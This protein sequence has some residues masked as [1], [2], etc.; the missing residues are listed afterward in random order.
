[1]DGKDFARHGAFYI[2]T[3]AYAY[4]HTGEEV[5]LKAIETIVDRFERKGV[6]AEGVRVATLGTLDLHMAAE[7]VPD[8]LSNKLRTFAAREDELILNSVVTMRAE[9]EAAGQEVFE[10]TWEARYS[11]GVTATQ[12][13]YYVARYEQI[14]RP[15]YRELVIEI[16]DVYH[17]TQPYEDAD[18]WPMSFGHIISTQVAAYHYTQKPEYLDQAERFAKMAI[19]RFWEDR[20]IP[21][22][23]LKTG[24]YESITGPDTLALALLQLHAALHKL[25]IP[26]P[27]NTLD[28]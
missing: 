18:C 2:G 25:D 16:A 24:H 10:P 14:K 22:A 6:N 26:I 13:M 5:F 4:K 20:P 17:G 21:R 15:E 12:A 1:V 8:P 23:S 7:R 9:K 28:R 27:S 11:S 3:W 19:D